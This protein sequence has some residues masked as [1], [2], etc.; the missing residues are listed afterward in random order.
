MSEPRAMSLGDRWRRIT[1]SGVQD[2]TLELALASLPSIRSPRVRIEAGSISAELEGAM[3][4]LHE[5]SIRV[6]PLPSRIWSQAVRVMRRS[7]S[8]LEALRAGRV[9]RSFDRLVARVAGEALLPEARRVTSA[10]TCSEVDSPC[11]HVLA[12]HELYARRLDDKPW[13]LLLLR[14][15]NL[16]DLLDRASRPP[17]EGELPPLPFGCREEPVLFPEGADGEL[18]DPFEAGQIRSLLGAHQS[19]QVET[20][21][22]M[23]DAYAASPTAADPG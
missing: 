7:A 11:R 13:E 5:V 1:S 15:V 9:P 17:A 6:P 14:G 3:G 2:H 18:D 21:S 8:M 23:I 19:G 20:V 12:L 4:A 16:R 22:R 10:C